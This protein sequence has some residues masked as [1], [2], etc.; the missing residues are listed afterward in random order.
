MRSNSLS[1]LLLIAAIGLSCT[2]DSDNEARERV[3]SALSDTLGKG[4]DPSVGFLNNPH[5]LQVSLLAARFPGASDSAFATEAKQIARF[6]LAR[7]GNGAGLDSI[8]VLDR[9]PVSDGV[10]RMH[11]VVTFAVDELRG[12]R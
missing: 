8:T 7:Y 5:R 6:T 2:R 11:H 4:A 12:A 10:W 1:K 3:V 9:E